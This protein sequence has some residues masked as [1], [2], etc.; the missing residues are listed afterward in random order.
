MLWQTQA[1]AGQWGATKDANAAAADYLTTLGLTPEQVE[2]AIRLAGDQ[3]AK[4]QIEDVKSKLGEIPKS[5]ASSIQADIDNGSYATALAKLNALARTRTVLFNVRTV[6][7]ATRGGDGGRDYRAAG[8]P[9]RAGEAYVVGEHQRELFVPNVAGRI[10]P[11]VPSHLGG[12]HG[13]QFTFNNYGPINGI[14]DLEATLNS[15]WRRQQA[16]RRFAS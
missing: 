10:L 4:A 7:S 3:Q 11:R 15:W 14:R 16:Q 8:G 9:V 1:L 6:D 12:D 13:G 5:V 2:T